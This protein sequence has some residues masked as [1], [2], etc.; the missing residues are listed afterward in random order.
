MPNELLLTGPRK[1]QIVPYDDRALGPGDVQADA[2]VSGLSHG[3]ELALYRGDTAFGGKRFDLD[4][5]LFAEDEKTQPYPV[6]L[7]YEWVGR[8]RAVGV[9]VEG[10]EVG[11][12]V[13]L[14]LPHRETHT[15][16]IAAD[17]PVPWLV[18]PEGLDPEQAALLQSTAIAIQAVHDARLKVGDRVAIFGLG[19]LGLLA[20]QL[21][22][23]SG[24]GW[25]AALDPIERRRELARSFG[26][27]CTL[28]PESSDVGR[29]IKLAAGG[30]GADVAI[31][32]SGR[33]EA[34]HEALRCVRLAGS[35]VAAGFYVGGSPP[36]L[37]LGEEFHHNRLTLVGSMSGWGAPHREPGWDRPRLR[38]TA[39]DLLAAGR[40]DVAAFITHRIPFERAA[41]AY[42][43]IG[44]R[45]EETLRVVLTY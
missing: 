8:V 44:R 12:R 23:L 21:A 17:Q 3:T 41:E 37:R 30:G 36:A 34:L 19:V 45:P 39:L 1:I 33:Y 43:L 14:T 2:I 5:R 15:V 31:E 20:V 18:L 4:L 29:E 7:G 22:R 35:V 16:T 6:R 9:D 32:F 28:D 40:L 11:D 13:H 24:A 25:V 27:D 10:I 42:E 26:A 38:A